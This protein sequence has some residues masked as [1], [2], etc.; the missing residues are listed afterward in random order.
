MIKTWTKYKFL[1]FVVVYLCNCLHQNKLM[2]IGVKDGKVSKAKWN[3]VQYNECYDDA[4]KWYPLSFM[5]SNILVEKPNNITSCYVFNSPFV[6][7]F[8]GFVCIYFLSW[9]YE[10]IDSNFIHILASYLVHEYGNMMEKKV[11][12][13]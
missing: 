11:Q 5:K 10:N 3:D 4:G 13:R 7:F 9:M 8:V 12:M 2:I 6:F 1:F